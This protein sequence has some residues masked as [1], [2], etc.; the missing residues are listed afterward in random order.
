[1]VILNLAWLLKEGKMKR[2]SVLVRELTVT[3]RRYEGNCF[4][5]IRNCVIMRITLVLLDLTFD[6]IQMYIFFLFQV[7][8]SLII[9]LVTSVPKRFGIR[10]ILNKKM[11]CHL[12]N[13]S[14]FF[15]YPI[16]F[17]II[18]Y[19]VYNR[20]KGQKKWKYLIW[21]WELN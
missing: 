3:F 7:Q 5:I 16:S 10:S 14:I 4:A 20:V 19:H 13:C 9:V 17:Y 6:Y 11:M 12:K 1:M 2:L 18:L 15:I 8:W 21:V